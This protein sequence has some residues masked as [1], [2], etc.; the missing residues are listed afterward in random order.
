[1]VEIRRAIIRHSVEDVIRILENEPVTNDMVSEVTAV[2]L[3]NRM[4]IAHLSI[5]RA[6]KFLIAEAGGPRDD[7][8]NL[9]ARYED[10]RK[11]DHE[12]ADSLEEVFQAAVRHYRYN[13][14]VADMNH[15]KSLKRYLE[16]AASN[17]AFQGIR[18]W[19]LTQS[20]DEMPLR[21]IYLLLHIELLHGLSDILLSSDRP[22]W[23]VVN[24]VE[25]AVENAMWDSHDL[26]YSPGSSREHSVRSYIEWRQGFS[27]W[28]DALASAFR[29]GFNIGDD[30]M[31]NLTRN[32]YRTL[33]ETRDLAVRYFASTLDVLPRQS[34]DAVPCVEWLGPEDYR[35]GSVH[36]P[37]GAPLGF[38]DR[39]PDGLWHITPLREG[40]VMSVSAKGKS[41]TDA[42][43]YLAA[44][45]TR[46]ARIIVEGEDRLIR[47]VGE[48]FNFFE[49]NY[50]VIN[51]SFEGE[52]P[53]GSWTHKVTLWG[54]DHG[55]EADQR[56]RIEVRRGERA[57][58]A[59]TLVATVTEVEGH[60]VYLSGY[61]SVEVIEDT[62]H[63]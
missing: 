2:Q 38:I 54:L 13:S 29:D 36:T 20:L 6:I 24:R 9:N 25:Q 28:C 44:L 27:T 55:I 62:A 31:A 50:D 61:E 51:R 45:L 37:S 5:E 47:I 1:M 4:A 11:H 16:L 10:L 46:P 3:M 23:T 39:G 57:D 35:S 40:L 14:N 15:L 22:V 43:C 52:D 53:E 49:Q 60:L 34:R 7:T 48:E 42:R 41:Q 30:F 32:A 56:V 12:V 19:E 18:Y 8:H 58:V 17:D 26:A 59:D 33:R 63:D 21:R